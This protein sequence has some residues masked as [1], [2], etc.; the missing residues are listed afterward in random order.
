MALRKLKFEE[1]AIALV[2]E[3]EDLHWTDPVLCYAPELLTGFEEMVEKHGLW[4]WCYVR[5][6]ATWPEAPY[7]RG[8][9]GL[10]CCSY[11]SEEAFRKDAY[12]ADL[13]KDA[14]ED[15]NREVQGRMEEAARICALLEEV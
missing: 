2:V 5:V 15:L 14:V 8:T 13:V 7:M 10:G 1:C 4:G 9:A 12:F 6:E 11:E 3:E